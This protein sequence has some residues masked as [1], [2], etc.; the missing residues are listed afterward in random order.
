M[1]VNTSSDLPHGTIDLE[2]LNI[3]RDEKSRIQFVDIPVQVEDL[4]KQ[5]SDD[6]K[7]KVELSP[8][9]FLPKSRSGPVTLMYHVTFFHSVY[10]LHLSVLNA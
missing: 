9:L 1:G 4:L 8:N 6:L 3:Y 10:T 2:S 7:A 5:I